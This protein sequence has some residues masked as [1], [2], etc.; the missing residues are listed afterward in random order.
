[1]GRR[2]DQTGN[3]VPFKSFTEYLEEEDKDEDYGTYEE[4]S[5]RVLGAFLCRGSIVRLTQSQTQR[6]SSRRPG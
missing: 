3:L 6:R 5:R 2:F 4:Y 1:M